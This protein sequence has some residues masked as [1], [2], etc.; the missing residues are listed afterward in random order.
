M[1]RSLRH[2]CIYQEKPFRNTLYYKACTKHFPV[3]LCTRKLAQSTPQYFFVLQSLHR[4]LLP[5]TKLAQSTPQYHF[6]AKACTAHFPVLLC[7]TKLAKR[8]SQYYFVLQSLHNTLP[9]S[10]WYYKARTKH[11]TVA[12]CTTKLAPVR[13]CTTKLVQSTAQYYFVLQ[14]LHH[15]LPSWTWYYKACTKYFPVL[16]CTTKL[17]QSTSH[18]YFVLQSLHKALACTTLYYKACTKNVPVLLCTTKLAHNTSQNTS[19]CDA[20]QA[21]PHSNLLHTAS[22]FYTKNAL[23]HSK[24]LGRR[25]F[26]HRKLL[27]TECFSHSKLL[28]KDV[29]CIEKTFWF[30]V[31]AEIAAPK[32][33]PGAKAK[34][35]ILKHFWKGILQG[36]SL[37]PK[38]GKS[39]HKQLSQPWC[40]HSNTI[41]DDQLQKTIVLRMQPR[42]QATLTQPLHCDIEIL[43]CKTQ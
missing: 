38:W 22:F 2:R 23:T 39:A 12:L 10:T 20:Q 9:S 18:H 33:D 14:S 27:H 4:I 28:H 21:F 34:K 25:A 3:L 35:N 37:A 43:N 29:F 26:T 31:R 40:S 42:H 30:I 7:T 16:F 19:R 41:Y 6:L 13:L 15:T 24:L 32:P 11:F 36:K 1:Y 17:A 8:T 5:S